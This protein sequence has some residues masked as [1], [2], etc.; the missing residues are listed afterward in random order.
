[1]PY[2]D[3]PRVDPS[4]ILGWPSDAAA[5][6]QP[7]VRSTG[8]GNRILVEN[9]R[10][11]EYPKIATRANRDSVVVFFADES[12]IRSN[13]HARTAWSPTGSTPVVDATGARFSVDM[14]SAVNAQGG[15]RFINV[16]CRL[17][18]SVLR[19]FLKPLITGNES[20]GVSHGRGTPGSQGKDGQKMCRGEP[21][22]YRV[23]LS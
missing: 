3:D 5:R 19:D 18:A 14:L 23:V 20:Q 13:Y 21:R 7:S 10:E 11:E 9:W 17:N 16:E 15:F 22:C 6:I 12:A 1:M 4:E 2:G 8:R